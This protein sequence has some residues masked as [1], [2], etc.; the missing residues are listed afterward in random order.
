LSNFK[1][2]PLHALLVEIVFL[3]DQVLKGFCSSRPEVTEGLLVAS[4]DVGKLPLAAA[5][6]GHKAHSKDQ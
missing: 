3:V 1:P 4:L 6:G 2:K 5:T